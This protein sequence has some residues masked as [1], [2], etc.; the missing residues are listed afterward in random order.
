M[1]KIYLFAFGL[2]YLTFASA[3]IN[4]T[5]NWTANKIKYGVVPGLQIGTSNASQVVWSDPDEGITFQIIAQPNAGYE[6]AKEIA[7]AHWERLI[8][9]ELTIRSTS[10]DYYE[11]GGY[12]VHSIQGDGW[13]NGKHVYFFVNGYYD[14]AGTYHA[15]GEVLYYMNNEDQEYNSSMNSKAITLLSAIERIED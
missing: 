8:A 10:G 7:N 3:Q 9:D 5:Y 12:Y 15:I 14:P 6:S 4:V 13:Q 1:K 2:F 11:T